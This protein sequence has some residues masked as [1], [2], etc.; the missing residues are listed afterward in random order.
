MPTYEELLWPS[1][2]VLLARHPD[3]TFIAVHFS[4]QGNDLGSLSRAL[5]RFPNPLRRPF[6][7]RLRESAASLR[8]AAR[9]L[10][11]YKDRRSVRKRLDAGHD[12]VSWLVAA[13]ESAD[14][15]TS[16]A[17]FGG[18]VRIDLQDGVL[19]AIYRGNA[20]RLLNWN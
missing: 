1:A 6:C 4:N 12:N 17:L 14:A 2:I 13:P 10:E 20:R 3:T 19:D 9:F 16:P 7:S 8:A 11:K 5:D 18:G 15:N